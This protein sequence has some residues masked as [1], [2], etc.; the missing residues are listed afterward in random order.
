MPVLEAAKHALDDVALPVDALAMLT[1]SVMHGIAVRARAGG[2][3]AQL[4][5]LARAAENFL[6]ASAAD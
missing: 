1:S 4:K 2:T 3:R 5:Q 6:L